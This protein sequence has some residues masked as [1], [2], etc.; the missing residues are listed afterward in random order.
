MCNKQLLKHALFDGA[1]IINDNSDGLITSAHA[2]KTGLKNQDMCIILSIQSQ[3]HV[4]RCYACH[5][6][7]RGC[8][9]CK[10]LKTKIQD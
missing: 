4:D 5:Y 7:H 1:N 10:V 6:N 8:F 2:T 3:K 9:T